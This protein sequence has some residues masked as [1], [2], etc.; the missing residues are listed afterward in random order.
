MFQSDGMW[1]FWYHRMRSANPLPKSNYNTK[2]KIL[3]TAIS[4]HWKST[5]VIQQIH[6]KLLHFE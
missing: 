2:N 6:E 4:R 1:D 5:K 3:K